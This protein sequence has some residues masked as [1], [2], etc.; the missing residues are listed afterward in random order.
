MASVEYRTFTACTKELVNG[1]APHSQGI[2][3]DL[4]AAKLIPPNVV[5]DMQLNVTGETKATE[6][7]TVLG[8]TI[9]DFKRK[10]H[11]VVKVLRK[12]Q[13]L[14]TLIALLDATYKSEHYL[15]MLLQSAMK[16]L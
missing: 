4:Q 5:Q 12:N 3:L 8:A 10:Y 1:I 11:D 13:D 15:E 6:L 16:W 7:V 9:S 2:A 14:E